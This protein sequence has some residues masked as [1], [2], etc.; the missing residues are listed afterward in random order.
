MRT[1]TT[2]QVMSDPEALRAMGIREVAVMLPAV[3]AEHTDDGLTRL[4]TPAGRCCC[5]RSRAGRGRASG[6]GSWRMR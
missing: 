2:A 5:Q 3:I 4:E 6:C 1:G